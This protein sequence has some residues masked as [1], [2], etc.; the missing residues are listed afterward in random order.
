MKKDRTTGLTQ[1]SFVLWM[2]LL[3]AHMHLFAGNI[4]TAVA[5]AGVA[6]LILCLDIR[7]NIKNEI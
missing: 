2:W 4:N 7:K 5:F 6:L 3:L 1:T